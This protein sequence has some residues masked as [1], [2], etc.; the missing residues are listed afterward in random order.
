MAEKD[1]LLFL[2]LVV[3]PSAT[4]GNSTI[5]D[6]PY[7]GSPVVSS[8]IVGGTD[9][10]DGS[11]PWQ[12]SLQYNNQHVCGGT[13]ISDQ[14]VMTAA[15]CF[16]SSTSPSDYRILL[17]GYKLAT[18]NSHQEYSSVKNITINKLYS[19]TGSSGDIAL[20]EL[21]NPV[22]YTSFILPVCIPSASI[23][24]PEGMECWVTGWGNIGSGVSLPY[25]ETLQQVML[26]LISGSSCNTMYHIGSDV[27]SSQ[28]IV[29][30]DQICAGFQAGVKDSCQGD[31][32]GP[33]VCKVQGV[34]YQVGVVS[35][36]DDCALLNRPGIYTLVS[37]YNA[38]IRSAVSSASL[39]FMSVSFLSA[40]CLVAIMFL[41]P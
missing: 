20:L 13:L 33:L 40:L 30:S 39:P 19:G 25:P 41:L 27:S 36:G 8:R 29:K 6:P 10:T 15:H 21:S 23:N 35:W 37:N 17:G 32:G 12:I 16:V 14:W 5:P 31:S 24:F 26:P 9:A 1:L 28:I 34:W 11:W 3:Y 22:T 7:C 2:L 38:W 4:L 18:T